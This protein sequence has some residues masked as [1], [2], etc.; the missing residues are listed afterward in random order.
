M[1]TLYSFVAGFEL[2]LSVLDTGCWRSWV[3]EDY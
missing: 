2:L 1:T 3:Q